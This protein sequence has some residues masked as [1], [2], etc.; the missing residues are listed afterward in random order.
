[1]AAQPLFIEALFTSPKNYGDIY[2]GT[3]WNWTFDLTPIFA[4]MTPLQ[5]LN[6]AEVKFDQ[7]E[8]YLR[9]FF[10]RYVVCGI[11]AF[12]LFM[13]VTAVISGSFGLAFFSGI[14]GSVAVPAIGHFLLKREIR[15]INADRRQPHKTFPEIID[16]EEG[17]KIEIAHLGP[18]DFRYIGVT[19]DFRVIIGKEKRLTALLTEKYSKKK[20]YKDVFTVPALYLRRYTEEN[21]GLEKRMTEER[22]ENLLENRGTY[23]EY[24]DTVSQEKKKLNG[25]A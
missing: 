3:S 10:G 21:H 11:L 17:D 19:D 16:W 6:E 13:V 15:E 9:P 18:E 5:F 25:N 8:V 22:K 20:K 12:L 24:L 2:W 14:L 4:I 7:G 1:V 23:Q